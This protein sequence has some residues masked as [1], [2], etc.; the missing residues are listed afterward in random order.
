M[1]EELDGEIIKEFVGL[2]VK[3]L[4]YLLDDSSGDKRAKSTKKCVIKK[5]KLKFED[6]KNLLEGINFKIK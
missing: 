1:K 3:I 2:R 5:R 6:Y 4:S